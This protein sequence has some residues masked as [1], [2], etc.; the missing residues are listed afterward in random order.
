MRIPKTP[1]VGELSGEQGHQF[2]IQITGGMNPIDCGGEVIWQI[3]M[4]DE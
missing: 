3:F 4:D 1:P 2:P